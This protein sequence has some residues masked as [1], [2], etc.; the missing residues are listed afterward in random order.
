MSLLNIK[1]YGLAPND[2]HQIISS[3][4]SIIDE[5]ITD[6]NGKLE[7]IIDDYSVKAY[8]YLSIQLTSL[9]Y[10]NFRYQ[11]LI[12]EDSHIFFTIPQLKIDESMMHDSIPS[13]PVSN[14]TEWFIQAQ[15]DMIED[16]KNLS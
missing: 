16:I 13:Y 1:I 14:V 3:K 10:E 9:L 7:Y 11:L 4:K 2:K 12:S 15:S 5:F 8:G 6:E